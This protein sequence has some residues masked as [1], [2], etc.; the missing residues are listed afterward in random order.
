MKDWDWT[1]IILCIVIALALFGGAKN[2]PQQVQN[3]GSQTPT[4][5]PDPSERQMTQSEI[6]YNLEQTQYK[7]EQIQKEIA[8]EEEKKNA[9]VY[10][11]KVT[12]Y[13]YPSTSASTE[14]VDIYASPSNKEPIN[15]T[16]W[17]LLSTSTNQS[18]AIPQSTFLYFSGQA[19]SEQPVYLK[20]GE[21]A[22]IITGRSPLGYGFKVNK[23]SGYLSQY[24]TFYPSLWTNCP[25][26]RD[27]DYSMVPNRIVNENCF[28]L[29]N[30]LP[31]CRIPEQLSNAYSWE[32]QAFLTQKINYPYCVSA[33]K[34]DSDFWSQQWYVY[35]KRSEPLWRTRRETIILYDSQDKVVS[36]TIRY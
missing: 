8:L 20:P 21:R 7:L 33:H 23:C 6:Q 4:T 35:L 26:P 28:D 15:I 19:N 13:V 12:F 32:C 34:D 18:V 31:S 16:G 24:N 11:D 3:V 22:Y 27:E 10:K 29:I 5:I 14:Y 9:S 1:L 36:K 30:S 17:R 25:A 2:T